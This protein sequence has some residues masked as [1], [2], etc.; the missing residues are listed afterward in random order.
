MAYYAYFT[1][2]VMS[3]LGGQVLDKAPTLKKLVQ[4]VG[5]IPQIKKYVETRPVTS[6]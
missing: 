1:T 5:E 6:A 4:R 2:P 3:K